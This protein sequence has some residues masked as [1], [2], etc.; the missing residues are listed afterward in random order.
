[1]VG[2]GAE[3][4]GHQGGEAPG[5]GARHALGA[6]DGVEQDALGRLP[7]R[8]PHAHGGEAEP[9]ALVPHLLA[10]PGPQ[11]DVQR[12]VE[13]RPRL[14][15]RYAEDA[16]LGELVAAA[17]PD[18]DAAAGGVVEQRHPLEEAQ[19][20]G[21]GEVHDGGPDPHPAR[22]GGEES[23]EQERV[24]REAVGREVLLRDP[25]VVEAERLGEGHALEL[26][27]DDASRLL[28]GRALEDV[29]GPEAHGLTPGW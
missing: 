25:D 5:H 28:A 23:G 1:V 20:V 13:D 14:V 21:E 29:V 6:V 7:R 9:A 3:R 12:L 22:A 8:R 16:V 11:H 17:H 10:P 2:E 24:A 15:D 19:R 27:G 18:L 26:L 4:A